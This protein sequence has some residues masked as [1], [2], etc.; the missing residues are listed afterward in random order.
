[1][2]NIVKKQI[3]VF[4]YTREIIT[5][6]KKGVLLTT[7]AE[8]HANT[9]TLGWASLGLDWSKKVFV[10]Y[11]RKSRF[12]KEQLDKNPEFTISVPYGSYDDRILGICG[13]KSGR[14]VDKIKELGLTLVEP[15]VISAPAI[16]EFPLTLECRVI[17]TEKQNVEMIIKEIREKHYPIEGSTPYE[18]TADNYHIAFYGEIVSAYIVE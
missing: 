16:K 6:F 12:T 3:E 4:D 14:D 10:A 15:D 18:G 11:V 8:G 7:M 2:E 9:M 1:M 13:S 17:C 5:S